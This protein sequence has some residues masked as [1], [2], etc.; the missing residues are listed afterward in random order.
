MKAP[1]HNFRYYNKY[2]NNNMKYLK[3]FEEVTIT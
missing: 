3:I 2:L 1:F